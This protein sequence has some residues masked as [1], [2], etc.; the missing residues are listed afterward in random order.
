M[1]SMYFILILRRIA[2]MIYC[3][4]CS[5]YK[6]DRWDSV[7]GIYCSGKATTTNGR[8]PRA[9]GLLALFARLS[10]GHMVR[11]ACGYVGQRTTAHTYIQD[12]SI[13]AFGCA[14]AQFSWCSWKDCSGPPLTVT[15]YVVFVRRC[16]CATQ[17]S[18]VSILRRDASYR[19]KSQRTHT[20]SLYGRWISFYGKD[21]FLNGRPTIKPASGAGGRAIFVFRALH[22]LSFWEDRSSDS[23]RRQ[24]DGKISLRRPEF[25]G[26]RSFSLLLLFSGDEGEGAGLMIQSCGPCESPLADSCVPVRAAEGSFPLERGS[27]DLPRSVVTEIP[28]FLFGVQVFGSRSGYRQLLP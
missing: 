16:C 15:L 28:W 8:R 24:T 21:G 22:C 25:V 18:V 11:V 27:R 23:W 9:P 7:R 13:R 26:A 5:Y 14:T 4:S 3:S 20:P 6:S 2:G 1:Y 10:A 12:N 19:C 17:S